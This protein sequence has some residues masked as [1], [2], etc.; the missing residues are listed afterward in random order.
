MTVGLNAVSN[1]CAQLC[2]AEERESVC[3]NSDAKPDA[4][5]VECERVRCSAVC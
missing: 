1:M 2:L 3:V 4:A 5:G